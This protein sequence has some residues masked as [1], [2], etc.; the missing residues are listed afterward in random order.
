[1]DS[2]IIVLLS[3]ISI[4]GSLK[5]SRSIFSNDFSG[6]FSGIFSFKTDFFVESA[7][8][9][10]LLSSGFISDLIIVSETISPPKGFE[11]IFPNSFLFCSLLIFI[12]LL[13]FSVLDSEIIVLFSIISANGSFIFSKLIFSDDCSGF[14]S[15]DIFWFL[16]WTFILLLSCFISDFNIVSKTFS[17][18]KGSKLAFPHS[19][20]FCS[21]LIFIT[22]LPISSF[23]SWIIVLLSG[24]SKN[25][26]CLFSSFLFWT[27]LFSD[28]FPLLLLLSTNL[29][30][31]GFW[32]Y[33][34][35]GFIVVSTNL[36]LEINSCFWLILLMLLC[37]SL[38]LLSFTL[39]LSS[40][41]VFILSLILPL[42]DPRKTVSISGILSNWIWLFWGNCIFLF[43]LAFI[44]L[45]FWIW[46]VSSRRL[47]SLSNGFFLSV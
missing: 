7:I 31:N 16:S 9:F 2:A 11:L 3:T 47:N 35:K 22:L 24:I 42:L 27:R 4:S 23:G 8:S 26:I 25:E 37:A 40:L 30:S 32:L 46:T 28:I 20:L 43:S 15:L 17:S 29:L 21:L 38:L 12:T 36:A 33:K 14:F 41:F 1:M 10:S 18:P 6:F 19:F 13:L 45:S 5:F 34:P 39:F 44:L